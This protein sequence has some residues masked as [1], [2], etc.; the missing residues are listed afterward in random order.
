MIKST[1]IIVSK[2]KKL[3]IASTYNTNFEK[4][5]FLKNLSK[6]TLR[7]CLDGWQQREWQGSE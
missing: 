2:D 6:R 3:A 1:F 4:G 7:L 5:T